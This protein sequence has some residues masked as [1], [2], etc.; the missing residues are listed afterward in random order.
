MAR[1]RSPPSRHIRLKDGVAGFARLCA[2]D[3]IE[4]LRP[5][6]GFK[7]MLPGTGSILCDDLVLR[8]MTHH[9]R[10]DTDTALQRQLAGTL[11]FRV[12]R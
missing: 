10:S 2:R 3:G 9:L 5:M 8:P 4:S 12:L 7:V 11:V 6:Q 1:S